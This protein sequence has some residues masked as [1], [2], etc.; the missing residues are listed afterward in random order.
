MIPSSFFIS[1]SRAQKRSSKRKHDQE[2]DIAG[3][4]CMC[5][6]VHE[7]RC[8]RDLFSFTSEYTIAVALGFLEKAG[9]PTNASEACCSGISFCET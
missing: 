8:K 2:S 5:L 3:I 7:I 1:S 4:V 9:F 6:C